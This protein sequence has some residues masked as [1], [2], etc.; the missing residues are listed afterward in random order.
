MKV[1]ECVIFNW[2]QIQRCLNGVKKKEEKLECQ[3]GIDEASLSR[4]EDLNI[5]SFNGGTEVIC[6]IE[7][8][9][10]SGKKIKVLVKKVRKI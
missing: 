1:L 5:Q 2:K 4:N 7:M 6:E 9:R 10:K 8:Y 3:K